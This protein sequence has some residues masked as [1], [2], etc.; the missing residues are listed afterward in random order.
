MEEI[1]VL[2]L[3]KLSSMKKVTKVGRI[4]T[5]LGE[6]ETLISDGVSYE[7]I[8]TEINEQGIEISMSHFKKMLY[9]LRKQRDRGD[10]AHG[11]RSKQSSGAPMETLTDGADST[12]S[13]NIDAT[14]ATSVSAKEPS[15]QATSKSIRAIFNK[16][17]DLSEFM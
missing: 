14:A 10:A 1:D 13:A 2:E 11:D 3:R 17:V 12:K 16:N 15:P 4:R 9:R 6:I 7:K 8:V 5:I